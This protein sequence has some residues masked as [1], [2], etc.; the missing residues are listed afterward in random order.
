MTSS[1][2]VLTLLLF[3]LHRGDQDDHVV[4]RSRT[5][6]DRIGGAAMA[7]S[8]VTIHE[9]IA[10]LVGGGQVA[11]EAKDPLAVAVART[12]VEE[13]QE[14]LR[15]IIGVPAALFPWW[16]RL[17]FV[18]PNLNAIPVGQPLNADQIEMLCK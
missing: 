9:E 12:P 4:W 1:S 2:R 11:P 16:R 14:R 10:S 5:G 3:H 8:R 13:Y 7:S 17:P 18:R 6:V 15:R